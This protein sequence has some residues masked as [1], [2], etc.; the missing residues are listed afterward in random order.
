[1][2]SAPVPTPVARRPWPFDVQAHRDWFRQAPEELMLVDALSHPG[3]Y[4]E[5]VDGEA[6]F[7][8]MLPLL[9][10][11]RV[12]S[13]AILDFDYEPLPYRRAWRVCGDEVLGVSDSVG[14][15]HRAI[16]WMHRLWIDG[17]AIVDE[18]GA[19]VELAGFSTW[20][21]DEVF[22]AE[23]PGPD[24]HPAQDFGPG[25]YPVILGLVVVDAGRGRTH[26]LQP[27]ATERW[28][29]PR[30]R[31]QG[32]R[33]QVVASESATEPDRVIDPAG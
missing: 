21:S 6:W 28:T 13:L 10:R 30:L 22:V 20:I 33:W 12:E 23:V 25:G 26:V 2:T 32:G 18:T 7:S 8:M 1:M 9:S 14:G 19:P 5:L 27:A 11:V 17:R 15:T 29:A 16:E 31:E 4:R 3:K 24:D